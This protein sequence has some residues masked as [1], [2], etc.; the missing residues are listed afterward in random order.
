[1]LA[2][3]LSSRGL[4]QGEE[5]IRLRRIW[6]KWRS[7]TCDGARILLC[8]SKR[9]ARRNEFSPYNISDDH[10]QWPPAAEAGARIDPFK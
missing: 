2:W 9:V 5:C 4:L 8:A 10:G 6:E 3:A 7:L 1:M